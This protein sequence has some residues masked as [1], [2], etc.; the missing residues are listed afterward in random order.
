[1]AESERAGCT[2]VQNGFYSG[3]LIVLVAAFTPFKVLGFLLPCVFTGWM[4]LF[5]REAVSQR[6]LVIL[7]ICAA[8][9]PIFYSLVTDELLL[10]NYGLA[11]LTYSAFLP[12]VIVDGRMLASRRLLE[13]CTR[14]AS[15]L[16]L[17]QGIVGTV[18]AVYGATQTGTFAGDNGDIV[19]GTIYPHLTP[20][21]AF[22]SAMFV[23]NIIVTIVVGL[24]I[25]S[26]FGGR[27]RI[28]L[29]VGIVAVVLA[30]VV[31]ALVYLVAAVVLAWILIRPAARNV[32]ATNRGR[33]LP[34]T[35]LVVSVLSYFAIADNVAQTGQVTERAFDLEGLATPRSILLTRVLT[36]LPDE[37]P[38]QPFVGLGPGQFSSRAS[39]I[40]SGL[41]LGK[42]GAPKSVPLLPP[43]ATQVAQ[44]YC[45]SLLLEFSDRKDVIGSSEQPFFSVLSIY[46]EL[47]AMGLLA[48]ALVM[49]T[50]L[51][52]I[53]RRARTNPAVRFSAALLVAGL[54]FMFLL[55]LQDNYW[56]TPQ[57]ILVGFLLLKLLY[58][59]VVSPVTDP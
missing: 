43:Q 26:T 17:I 28:H 13:R 5:A 1:V 9:I 51:T 23:V 55:G 35:I 44:D 7:A 21:R 32:A 24:S 27:R 11:L 40:A 34:V 41:Y 57:A 2:R 22:G 53:R 46:T 58:V 42:P 10:S 8:A 31:H 54:M 38:L 49:V 29:A 36:E 25:P 48:V 39:L 50:W 3:F 14:A 19:A 16:V 20:E 37:Q 4:L 52:E 45:F 33:G 18:Q 15:V 56:E 30:S 47:G 59:N 6:R 12:I